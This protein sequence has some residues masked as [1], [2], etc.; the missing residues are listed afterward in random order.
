MCGKNM[1]TASFRNNDDKC[2]LDCTGKH[3]EQLDSCKNRTELTQN[4]D[5][6]REELRR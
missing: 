2:S 1:N 3:C 5:R 6:W 4:F